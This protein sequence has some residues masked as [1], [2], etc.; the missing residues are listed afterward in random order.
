VPGVQTAAAVSALPLDGGGFYLGRVFLR[1]GAAEPPAGPE[2]A[3]SW[4]VVTPDYFNAMDIG[5]VKGRLFTDRD[6]AQNPPVIII[7]EVFAQRM[8]PN[9]DPLGK[10]I[11][12]WRD[13]NRLREIVGVVRDVHYRGLEDG[14]SSLVYIPHRQD[15]WGS[16][17]MVVRTAG[18]PAAITNAVQQAFRTVDK[19]TPISNLQTLQKVWADST[20]RQRFGAWMLG[21]FAGLALCLAG[22]GIY[23]VMSY[24]VTQR[25]HEIGIRIALG[26]R[27]GDVLKLVLRRGAILT[28]LGLTLGLSAAFGL[29]RLMSGL[30][31]GVSAADPATFALIALLLMVVALL[32][33][34]IPARRATRVDPIIALRYE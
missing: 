12:S 15:A 16:L 31:Y 6:D 4:N 17:T 20:V 3:G 29:T 2:T 24:S 5:L 30:L 14:P 22:I 21:L 9:E 33:C 1:E 10:R 13:E 18:D 23:G 27:R 19:E 25:T 26:A 28:L 8:F 7:S 34:W 11:R 32:A